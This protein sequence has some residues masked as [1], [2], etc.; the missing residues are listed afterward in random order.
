MNWYRLHKRSMPYVFDPS[1]DCNKDGGFD[2]LV[3]LLHKKILP[4]RYV[5]YLFKYLGLDHLY[6][7]DMKN[8][9]KVKEIVNKEI[10]KRDKVPALCDNGEI[11][12]L[13]RYD[14]KPEKPKDSED[15]VSIEEMQEFQ[16]RLDL[17]RNYRIDGR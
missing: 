15:E 6:P 13:D 9:Q 2:M 11:R 8:V 7:I 4:D 16:R 5:K 1:R 10:Y 14:G 3:E 17:H 12:I